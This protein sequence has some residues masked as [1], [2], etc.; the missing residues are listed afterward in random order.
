MSPLAFIGF[1]GLL[2]CAALFDL[3]SFRIPNWAPL[4]LAA[5]VALYLPETSAQWLDRAAAVAAVA[6]AGGALWFGGVLGG[7]DYKLIWACSLWLGLN[8]LPAFLLALGAAGALQ[9]LAVALAPGGAGQDGGEASR[10]RRRVPLALSIAV[11]G[12]YWSAL[13]VVA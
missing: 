7:G 3:R 2:A 13:Q 4:A 5:T 6:L 8:G 9:G 12:L 11:A 1:N 10:L